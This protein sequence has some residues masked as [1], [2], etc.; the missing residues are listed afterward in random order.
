MYHRS[1]VPAP[2][3]KRRGAR[4]LSST[5]RCDGK[6]RRDGGCLVGIV[7]PDLLKSRH[8]CVRTMGKT[9]AAAVRERVRLNSAGVMRPFLGRL[10]RARVCSV[11]S[12][13]SY[14]ASPGGDERRVRMARPILAPLFGPLGGQ[15][16]Q[17]SEK[18]ECTGP[19]GMKA[20]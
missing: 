3:H 19:K 9:G 17:S 13:A 2:A 18:S 12:H 5:S 6:R 11:L 8:H 4:C 20:A 7:A 1:G 16:W 15:H 14:R 10:L